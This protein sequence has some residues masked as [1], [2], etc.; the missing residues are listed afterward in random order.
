MAP[1]KEH[2]G[3]CPHCSAPETRCGLCRIC[4]VLRYCQHTPCPLCGSPLEHKDLHP[5][6][7][8]TDEEWEGKARMASCKVAAGLKDQLTEVEAR[9]LRRY[10]HPARLTAEGYRRPDGT[11]PPW[12]TI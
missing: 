7:R 6:G 3:D 8:P 12:A 1:R 9:A 10:P 5:E 11:R 2:L 4:R